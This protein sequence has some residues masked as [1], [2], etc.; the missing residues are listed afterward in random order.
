[1]KFQASI[2][3]IKGTVQYRDED[4]QKIFLPLLEK[5]DA[6]EEGAPDPGFSCGAARDGEEHAPCVSQAAVMRRDSAGGTFLR[7]TGQDSN[8]NNRD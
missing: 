3:G 7:G 5:W 1:M 4:V 6:G 8:Y 2:N